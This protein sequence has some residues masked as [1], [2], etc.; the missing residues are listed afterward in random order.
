MYGMYSQVLENFQ[1]ES[2]CQSQYCILRKIV[3]IQ[4]HP[5]YGTW[6]ML[7]MLIETG[8]GY[9]SIYLCM[10]ISWQW[11]FTELLWIFLLLVCIN[12]NTI[13][14]QQTI[15]CVAS[16]SVLKDLR[17]YRLWWWEFQKTLHHFI[18]AAW[19]WM[20]P[21]KKKNSKS[22]FQRCSKLFWRRLVET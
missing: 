13:I 16:P 6:L 14:S 3:E 4:Y 8:Q 11:F 10:I 1:Q 17:V 21:K 18:D 7:W 22:S 15:I 20:V 5:S 12:C 9:R 19:W 2:V